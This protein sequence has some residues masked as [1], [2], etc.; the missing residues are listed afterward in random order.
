M[1]AVSLQFPPNVNIVSA[2][3][4]AIYHRAQQV[5]QQE[6]ARIN[7]ESVTMI[8][9]EESGDTIIEFQLARPPEGHQYLLLYE[10]GH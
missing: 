8:E 1:L 5:N 6:T 10:P 3:A 7:T 2:Y 9:S 4:V